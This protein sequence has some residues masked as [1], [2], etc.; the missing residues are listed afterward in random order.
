MEGACTPLKAQARLKVIPAD[1]IVKDERKP[2]IRT[3]RT[4]I[5][6]P[7]GETWSSLKC[8]T[9]KQGGYSCNKAISLLSPWL[10]V[11]SFQ[12]RLLDSAWHHSSNEKEGLH[13]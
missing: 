2:T 12:R 7:P 10:E 5:D 13:P 6:S 9:G 1:S 4:S 3:R 11:M 8:F